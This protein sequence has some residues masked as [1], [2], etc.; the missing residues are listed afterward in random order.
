MLYALVA[1]ALCVYV[2]E[3]TGRPAPR[4]DADPRWGSGSVGRILLLGSTTRYSGADTD[5]RGV[6]GC[7]ARI[8]LRGPTDLVSEHGLPLGALAA[9]VVV[10]RTNIFVAI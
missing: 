4:S 8:L 1:C 7:R 9:D 6:S 10:S 3:C 2:W 5:S